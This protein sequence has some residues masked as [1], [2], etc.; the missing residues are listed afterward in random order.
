MTPEE[1][2]SRLNNVKP[3]GPGRWLASCPAHDDKHPSFNVSTGDDGKILYIC[4]SGCDQQI[5]LNAMGLKW[6]DL[7]PESL[8]RIPIHE[9]R[10]A[11]PSADVLEA[12]TDEAMLV[13]VA[14]SNV[15]AGVQL[16]EEDLKR[17]WVAYTRIENARRLTLGQRR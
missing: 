3:T 15:A 8:K 9:Y 10:K 2:V 1:F 13:A 14:A 16:T 7:Y 4:R 5:V 12:L 6:S 17:V 11:F